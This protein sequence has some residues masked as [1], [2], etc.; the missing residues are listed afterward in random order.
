MMTL[1]EHRDFPGCI[2]QH[3]CQNKQKHHATVLQ[4]AASSFDPIRNLLS[5]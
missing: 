3:G 2:P 1:R 5:G 4:F